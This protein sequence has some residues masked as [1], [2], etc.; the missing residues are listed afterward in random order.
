MIPEIHT[1]S[2]SIDNVEQAISLLMNAARA[3]SVFGRPVERGEVT[4]IPCSEVAVGF[5]MGGGTRARPGEDQRKQEGNAGVGGGGGARSHPVAAI[6][7]KGDDVS[8]KPIMDRTKIL[9]AILTTTGFALFW[10]ARLS[11]PGRKS[12]PKPGFAPRRLR[13]M[14][15]RGRPFRARRR[16]GLLRLTLASWPRR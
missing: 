4:V 2:A 10:L 14:I 16:V 12:R 7:I 6:I 15:R 1:R 3:E 13:R 5:G 11:L 9:Q 8:V